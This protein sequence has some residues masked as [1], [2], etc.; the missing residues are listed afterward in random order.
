MSDLFQFQNIGNRNNISSS[1]QPAAPLF[2]CVCVYSVMSNMA[3][4][5]TYLS[6]RWSQRCLWI[7]IFTFTRF[8]ESIQAVYWANG[9]SRNTTL[10]CGSALITR[11]PWLSRNPVEYSIYLICFPLAYKNY[12]SVYSNAKPR[13]EVAAATSIRL[14]AQAA[15][16]SVWAGARSRGRVTCGAGG[17]SWSSGCGWCI[18]HAPRSCRWWRIRPWSA[19]GK[20]KRRRRRRRRTEGP[21]LGANKD[22]PAP[23]THISAW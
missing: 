19:A 13:W 18:P 6:N 8:F 11:R 22:N 4:A 7:R 9:S 20:R 15:H 21:R 12:W 23:V 14:G 3:D 2:T 1:R 17:R 16:P 5:L 10:L